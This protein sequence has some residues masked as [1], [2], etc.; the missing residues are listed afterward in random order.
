MSL[1]V[2]S[3]LSYQNEMRLML[4]LWR[5]TKLNALVDQSICLPHT[6]SEAGQADVGL[7][8]SMY[9]QDGSTRYNCLCKTAE[10]NWAQ[11]RT[12]QPAFCQFKNRL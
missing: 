2:T 11:L 8:D 9:G 12:I 5:L 3:G 4:N 7:S 6:G 10:L 1:L